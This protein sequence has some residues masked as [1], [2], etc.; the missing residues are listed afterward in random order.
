MITRKYNVG[1]RIWFAEEKKPYV[2][3]ACDDRFLVCTKPY[4]FKPKKV[5]Y[6]IV[7]LKEGIRGTD[8]Y[9][10]CPYDYYYPKDCQG[11]LFE[12]QETAKKEKTYV[13]DGQEVVVSCFEGTQIS[14]R[15]RI[16]LNI[17]KVR[18]YAD[19]AGK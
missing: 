1:D 9:S 19:K 13:I 10:I 17:V 2:V 7:D 16:E 15:N 18:S 14:H 4:N 3:K 11:L 6:T 12:L 8:N 5:L